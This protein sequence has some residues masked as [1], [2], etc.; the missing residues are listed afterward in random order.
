MRRLMGALAAALVL[1][2]GCRGDA[3]PKTAPVKGK[4]VFA[5]G[6]PL[7]GGVVQL[8]PSA[9]TE[10]VSVTGTIGADGSFSLKTYRN[11]QQADGAPPGEYKVTIIRLIT[12]GNKPPDPVTLPKPITIPA[13]GNSDLTLTLPENVR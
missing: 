3:V 6:A 10:T 5:T 8:E 12:D 4:V 2:A 13:G 9:V 7:T 11:K 1:L